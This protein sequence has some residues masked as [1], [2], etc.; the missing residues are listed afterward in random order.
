VRFSAFFAK[1]GTKACSPR[2]SGGS[3]STVAMVAAAKKTDR[4]V[5]WPQPRNTKEVRQFCGLVRYIAHFLPQITEHTHVL[6][7][8]TTK[9]CNSNFLLW[10]KA[11][12]SAFEAIKKAVIGR[13]CLTTIDHS[14]MP[15]MK[16]FVTTDASDFQL[17]AVLS[18][19][20]T[21]DTA[22]P[23]AFN[24]MTFKGAELNYPV[25]EK[26][27]LAVVC[28][29]KKWRSDLLGSQ[30]FMFTDHRTLENFDSQ[31]DLSRRQARW[32]EHLSQFDI[33]IHYIRGEDNTVAD[34]LSQLPDD[35]CEKEPED[36]DVA[37]SPV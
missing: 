30:F 3:D 32:M 25:H 1:P 15:D 21:W 34:T 5:N 9:E 33:T 19:G 4:I 28:T 7:E 10:N 14:L 17:G 27:M 31:K 29:L 16:V 36:V 24:S 26:E 22:W 2:G 12:Q 37:D 18:F 35:P 20:K 6:M 11:H 8:L 23:V 13:D